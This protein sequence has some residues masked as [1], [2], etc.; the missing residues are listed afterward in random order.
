MVRVEEQLLAAWPDC[1][2]LKWSQAREGKWLPE[3]L[4]GA[5]LA[6]Q[7]HDELIYEVSG[8]DVVQAALIVKEGMEGAVK[9]SVPTPVRIKVGATWGALQ[10]FSI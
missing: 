8:D 7:L 1:R 10:E 6:L 3:E 2:P 4:R 5:W 9:F